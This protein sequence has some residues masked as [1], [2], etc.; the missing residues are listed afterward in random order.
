[1]IDS[2]K[3]KGLRNR[4]IDSL[5]E[6]GIS[7]ETVLTAMRKVPRHLFVESALYDIAYEDKPL[8]IAENQTI[9]QPYTVAYQSALLQV[10]KGQKVLEIGT[11]SGYQCAI[12]CEMGAK[13]FTIEIV[14]SLYIQAQRVLAELDYSPTMRCGDGSVGWEENAPFDRILVTAACPTIPDPL[15]KQLTIGG[16]LVLPVGNSEMQEMCLVIRK[17]AQEWEISRLEKFRFVPLTGKNGF[18]V[19]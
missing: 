3:H 19:V 7:A 2:F 13:V 16:R 4:L 11:G 12:L 6:N 18:R 10:K 8:P 9:S 14:R 5:E 17:S 1:M 15:K